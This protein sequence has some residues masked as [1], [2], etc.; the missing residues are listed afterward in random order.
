MKYKLKIV[1]DSATNLFYWA[2]HTPDFIVESKKNYKHPKTCKL[3]ALG[4]AKKQ[5]LDWFNLFCS[6]IEYIYC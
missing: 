6:D 1:Q 5:N 2:Y 4:W 3:K